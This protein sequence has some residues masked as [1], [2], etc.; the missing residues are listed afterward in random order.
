MINIRNPH[1]YF[2]IEEGTKAHLQPISIAIYE[3]ATR[4]PN[5]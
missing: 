5:Y 3:D 4:S 1:D 2:G